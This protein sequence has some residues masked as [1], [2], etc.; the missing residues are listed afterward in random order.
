MTRL[1]AMV[2]CDSHESCICMCG[3]LES[4]E[5]QTREKEEGGWENVETVW[6]KGA[7]VEW[8]SFICLC[9][10]VEDR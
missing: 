7:V 4:Q 2:G 5:K 3:P 8:D 1:W 10:P 9:A 6:E